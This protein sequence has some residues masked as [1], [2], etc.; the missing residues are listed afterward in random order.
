MIIP[1][2]SSRRHR[3]SRGFTLVELL[4]VI[5]IIAILISIILPSLAAAKRQANQVKC[6][7]ALRQIGDAF[8]MYAIDYKGIWPVSAYRLPDPQPATN[9][10]WH[11]WTTSLAK[12]VSKNDPTNRGDIGKNRTM[13]ILWGCPEWTRSFDYDAGAGSQSATSNYTG[14]GMN[15]YPPTWLRDTGDLTKQSIVTANVKGTWTKYTVWNQKGA[16]RLLVA[17]SQIEF[18][19]APL[20]FFRSTA[21]FQP[22]DPANFGAPNFWI[23]SRHMKPG[24]AKRAALGIKSVNTLFCDG[25]ASPLSVPEAWNAIVNPGADNVKP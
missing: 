1:P 15:Y 10:P 6:L 20:S 19:Y 14:Y 23:D 18:I 2:V 24:T 7:A 17:D 5:G 8:K 16:D 3:D 13:S 12:Y 25:H 21:L 11:A 4:V 9:S 22:Y